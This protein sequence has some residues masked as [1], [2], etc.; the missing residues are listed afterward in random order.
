[1]TGMVTGTIIG[2]IGRSEAVFSC[3]SPVDAPVPE[4]TALDAWLVTAGPITG[5]ATG[6]RL[7]SCYK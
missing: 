5:F 3:C 2:V 1:M 4:N 6:L 7:L